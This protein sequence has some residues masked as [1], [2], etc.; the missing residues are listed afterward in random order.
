MRAE[1][2]RS[3]ALSR[4]RESGPRF[5]VMLRRRTPLAGLVEESCTRFVSFL[6]IFGERLQSNLAAILAYT[7]IDDVLR[8][9]DRAKTAAMFA[10]WGRWCKQGEKVDLLL[11][12]K[13]CEKL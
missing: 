13:F 2:R 7:C 11:S 9:A 4:L 8:Q 5:I 3:G 1:G 10:L 6:A 12:E